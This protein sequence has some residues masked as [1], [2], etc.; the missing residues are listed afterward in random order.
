[1]Q[2]G[3]ERRDVVRHPVRHTNRNYRKAIVGKRISKHANHGY[4]LCCYG[5]HRYRQ[6]RDR[7]ARDE[8]GAGND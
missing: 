6:Y 3:S 7:L 1:M 8:A 4:C 2:E 5:W